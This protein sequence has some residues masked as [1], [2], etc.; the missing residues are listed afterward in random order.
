MPGLYSAITSRNGPDPTS[1]LIGSLTGVSAKRFGIMKAAKPLGLESAVSAISVGSLKVIV[2]VLA[3]TTVM[4]SRSEFMV[5]PIVSIFDQ[6]RIE[7]TQSS[8]FT[9]VPSCHLSPS[10]RRK[11]T[12]RPSGDTVHVSAICGRTLLSASRASSVS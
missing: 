7:A 8:A 6:R 9:S 5:C 12:T 10:R 4:V 3:S 11:V 2:K 1:S